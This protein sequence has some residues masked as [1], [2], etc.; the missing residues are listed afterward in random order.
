MQE[1]IFNIENNSQFEKLALEAFDYQM[2]YNPI[3]Q[4]YVDLVFKNRIP[5]NILEIPF[6]PISFFKT[7]KI[8]CEGQ[9]VKTTFLSSG[10]KGKKK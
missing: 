5:K 9:E 6:L 3:Y 10:T 1:N 2:H 8:I 7:E 4:K